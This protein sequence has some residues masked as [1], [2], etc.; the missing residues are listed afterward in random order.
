MTQTSPIS[1]VKASLKNNVDAYY[2]E[3]S[4]LKNRLSK[5]NEKDSTFLQRIQNLKSLLFMKYFG[6]GDSGTFTS[7]YYSEK[8]GGLRNIEGER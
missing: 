8:E 4:K 1:V 7:N 6:A 3:C 2:D 5:S